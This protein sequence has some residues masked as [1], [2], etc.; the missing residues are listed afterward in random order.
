VCFRKAGGDLDLDL[1]GEERL[2]QAVS[3]AAVAQAKLQADK[4]EN[5]S[6]I[7]VFEHAFRKIKEATGVSDVNEVIQKIVSQVRIRNIVQACI[8]KLMRSQEST[9]ESLVSLT[10]ETQQKIQALN[11]AKKQLKE[12]IED[13]K[14]RTVRAFPE[15]VQ[16]RSNSTMVPAEAIGGKW[17]MSM[18]SSW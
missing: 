4:M 8:T 7:D 18:R 17:W 5:R 15:V 14:V 11:E 12:R 10:R 2:Q 13:I 16:C 3:Q 1:V 9:T 6:K